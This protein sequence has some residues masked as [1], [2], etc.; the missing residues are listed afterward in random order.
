[1]AALHEQQS[2]RLRAELCG[3]RAAAALADGSL[4]E[5]A[6]PDL[7]AIRCDTYAVAIHPRWRNAC[8]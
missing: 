7:F 4:R 3:E 8:L 1:M 6:P 2:N 5:Q